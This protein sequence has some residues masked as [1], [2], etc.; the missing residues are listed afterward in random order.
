MPHRNTTAAAAAAPRQKRAAKAAKAPRKSRAKAHVPTALERPDG[1][2]PGTKMATM[3]DMVLTPRGATEAEIC[4]KIGWKKCR[5]TLQRTAK[6]AGA[7]LTY[8]VNE[9]GEKVWKAAM[10]AKS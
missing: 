3:L 5:V 6:K 7:E 2:R 9:K 8:E 10:P 4:N 1:L